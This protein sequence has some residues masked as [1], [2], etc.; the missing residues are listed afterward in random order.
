MQKGWRQIADDAQDWPEDL[1]KVLFQ[2]SKSL[3]KP[4][5]LLLGHCKQRLLWQWRNI[6]KKISYKK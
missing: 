3:Q 5:L 2:C 4:V 1:S 6:A